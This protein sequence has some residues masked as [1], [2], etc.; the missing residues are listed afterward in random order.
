MKLL[1]LKGKGMLVALSAVFLANGLVGGSVS[2]QNYDKAQAQVNVDVNAKYSPEDNFTTHW[3]RADALKVQRNSTNTIPVIP[4]TGDPMTSD[5]VYLGD[6]WP[7]TNL[8]G[9]VVEYKGWKILFSLTN[10]KEFPYHDGRAFAH[11][12][13]YYSKDGKSWIYGGN[14]FPEGASLGSRTWSGS[15]VIQGKND[16]TMF[17]TAV[18]VTG[19][20]PDNADGRQSLASATGK[21]EADDKGVRF[22]GFGKETH[23]ILAEPDGV[24]YQTW[25]QYQSA[26]PKTQFP[27]FRDPW[28]FKDPNDGKTYMVFHASKGGNPNENKCT[29]EDIGDVPADHVVPED[30]KYFVG[31]VGMAVATDK[32]LKHWKLLPPLLTANCVSQELERP[33]FIF[34]DNKYYLFIDEHRHKYAPGLTGPDGLYGFVGTSLRSKYQPLNGSSLVLANPAEAN[35]QSFA[36]NIMPNGLV[37]SFIMDRPSGVPGGNMAPTVKFDINGT[38]THYVSQLDYGYIEPT[39][40]INNHPKASN[41]KGHDNNDN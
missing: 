10:S 3:T 28:V 41:P 30:S 4:Q 34:K 9:D 14:V 2:A 8:N 32:E 27:G 39:T 21:I 22:T 26:Q 38:S 35:N 7:L 29:A 6:A 33:H 13:F 15:A 25:D 18:G 23:N 19:S 11:I 5:K 12:G 31:E 20:V 24:M 40:Y 37:Q 36:F 16:I 1:N 17:Y